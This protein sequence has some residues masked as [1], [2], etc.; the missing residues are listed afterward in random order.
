M[1]LVAAVLLCIV[2]LLLARLRT[3]RSTL[4]RLADAAESGKPFLYDIASEWGSRY[5]LE[6]L[7]RTYN[8]L[9]TEREKSSRQEQ[10][11][12]RQLEV[13]LGNLTE[14]VVVVDNS[15]RLY[16]ANPAARGLFG[17]AGTLE[18]Q[19]IE[20]VIQSA[21]FL[22]FMRKIRY[23]ENPGRGHIEILS[24]RQTLFLEVAGAR[25]PDSG[26]TSRDLTLFVMHDVTNLKR[27]EGVRKEFV[28]NVSHELRTPVTIIK[29]YSDTLLDDYDTLKDADRL[30]FLEKIHKNVSR[31][32]LLLEDLL[33]LS[34]L[35]WETD[36]LHREPVSL[37][38][39]IADAVENFQ[40]RL[41]TGV[42][43]VCLE[44]DDRGDKAMLDSVKISQV[45]QNLL[46]NTIRYA[47]GFDCLC[48]ATELKGDT[49]AISVQDNGCGIPEADV[50]H[51]FERFYRVDKGRSRESG[52]TGLGL[53]IVKHI[54]QLHG[55]EV[56]ASSV[57]GE[58]TRI[59]IDIPFIAVEDGL[60]ENGSEYRGIPRES[61]RDASLPEART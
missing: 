30:R 60:N 48:I 41:G 35:E 53:S 22:E 40:Q 61:V 5:H 56:R 11:Y 21:K 2:L 32:H 6:R 13:T 19:K 42:A 59:E 23:E 26:D 43:E 1:W 38:K 51:I 58:G 52:G 47:K 49:L 34:R 46:D 9:T 27:L 25:I 3:L 12:L 31:L 28:A 36:S 45:F 24:G 55:G 50:E 37:Q 20:S 18:G 29:G 4:G 15:G 44:L 14:A 54:V 39:I 10:S 57:E 17:I 7:S 33:V 8:R 16:L